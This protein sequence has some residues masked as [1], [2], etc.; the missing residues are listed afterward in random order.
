[1]AKGTFSLPRTKQ[2]GKCPW[3]VSTN[4]QDIPDGYCEVKH[5]NLAGTISDGQFRPEDLHKPMNVMAC[6]HSDGDD[7]MYCIGWLNNQLGV[8][9]NIRLRLNMMSC[10]NIGDMKVYG[11]QHQ[12]FED[13]LPKEK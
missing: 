2:C 11:P 13:T 9:N 6:H 7:K 3:K 8:G 10:D 12:K 1:M 4:P 5:K